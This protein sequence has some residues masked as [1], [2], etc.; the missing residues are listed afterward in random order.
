M[1]TY[2]IDM[3]Y[4]KNNDFNADDFSVLK[5]RNW[6]TGLFV[7]LNYIWSNDLNK[8]RHEIALLSTGKPDIKKEWI[9]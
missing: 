2:D 5:I 1:K 3:T 9:K 8:I 4:N 6:K 7:N